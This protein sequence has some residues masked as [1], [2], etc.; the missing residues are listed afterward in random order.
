MARRGRGLRGP[1]LPVTVPAW[2][3]RA[4]HFDALVLKALAPIDARWHARLRNLDVAVDDVPPV[5][6]ADLRDPGAVTFPP[7]VLADGAVALA[8][9]VPAGVDGQGMATRARIVLFRRPLELRSDEPGD[10][11]DLL[12]DVLVEQVAT[13]LGVAPE[14]IDPGEPDPDEPDP[15]EP[16][17]S[18]LAL[19]ETGGDE[20]GGDDSG[21]GG[22]APDPDAAGD[23][24]PGRPG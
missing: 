1:V 2:R 17:L 15:D 23:D 12:H 7:E 6:A 5:R 3:S 24:G 9:L 4:Q 22:N 21:P 8:R 11:A 18:G 13:Y 20:T 16:D 14:V 10:L 19:G